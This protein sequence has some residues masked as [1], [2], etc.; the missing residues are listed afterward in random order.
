M[1]KFAGYDIGDD[2]SQNAPAAASANDNFGGYDIAPAAPSENAPVKNAKGGKS[3]LRAKPADIIPPAPPPTTVMSDPGG[4]V[5]FINSFPVVGPSLVKAGSAIDALTGNYP[6]ATYADRYGAALANN[7]QLIAGFEAGHPVVAPVVN[8][9]G[10]ITGSLPAMTAAPALFGAG[11]GSLLGRTALSALTGGSINAADTAA[12]GGGMGDIS[13]SSVLG[14]ALGGIAPA[15]GDLVG[16]GVSAL[17]RGAARIPPGVSNVASIMHESGLTPMQVEARLAQLG[18]YGTLADVAP[19]FQ[20][21]AGGLAS[22]GGNPTQVLKSAM[23]A[24]AAGKDTRI[25]DTVAQHIG[26]RPDLTAEATG[27]QQDAHNAASPYYKAAEANP[28]PMDATPVVSYIDSQLQNAKGGVAK[29]LQMARGL[30]TKPSPLPGV[31]IPEDNAQGLLGARQALDDFIKRGGDADTTA[32]ANSLRQAQAVRSQIDGLVKQD[33]N[34]AAGDAAYSTKISE[35][36]ALDEGTNLFKPGTRIEDVQRSLAAKTPE[37]IGA[38]QKGALAALHDRLDGVS[39]DWGA[40][41]QMF[42]K[43]DANRQKLDALFPGAQSLFDNIEGEMAMRQT[44]QNVAAGSQTA[45][46]RAVQEKYAP[47]AKVETGGILPAIT[48]AAT[49][50]APGVAASALG[51]SAFNNIKTASRA[52]LINQTA[53][54]LATPQSEISPLM[55]Q[56]TRAFHVQPKISALSGGTNVLGNASVRNQEPS[57]PSW[58]LPNGGVS[59]LLSLLGSK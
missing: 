56:I 7:R 10:A 8:A 3:Q 28:V 52:K 34:I 33:P 43:S 6:G 45:A 55:D 36:G 24:R 53:R 17:S 15:A 47:S 39:G 58:V 51:R 44:E 35:K 25:S 11:E 2:P 23:E 21:E 22:M 49:A 13:R 54:A 18:P 32:G 5:S 20:N 31:T 30:V 42:G 4:G 14:M 27:I 37:Q 26:P 1:A 9:A 46:R 29:T 57:I 16:A 38:M 41:R 19:A 12:R 40:A 59:A 50:G 48:G